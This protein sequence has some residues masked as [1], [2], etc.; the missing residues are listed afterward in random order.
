MMADRDIEQIADEDM[1]CSDCGTIIRW[2][3]ELTVGICQ[4]CQPFHQE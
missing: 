2:P 3:Q 1:R 4:H